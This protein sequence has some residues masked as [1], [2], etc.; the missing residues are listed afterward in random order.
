MWSV[1][2]SLYEQEQDTVRKFTEPIS[3]QQLAR[4]RYSF[5][6]NC[7]VEVIGRLRRMAKALTPSLR[8]VFVE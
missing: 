8:E 2:S 3:Q 5:L 7:D 6:S 1:S 4:A